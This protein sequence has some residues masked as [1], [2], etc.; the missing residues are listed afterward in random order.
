MLV[1]ARSSFKLFF[2]IENAALMILFCVLTQDI[3]VTPVLC[4]A[5][6]VWVCTSKKRRR[7]PAPL[8]WIRDRLG[9]TH[10][11]SHPG[12]PPRG[13]C[14]G[15]RLGKMNLG[16]VCFPK[17]LPADS[18]KYSSAHAES[19]LCHTGPLICHESLRLH[20]CVSAFVSQRRWTEN[21]GSTQAPMT[22]NRTSLWK[23]HRL[24]TQTRVRTSALLLS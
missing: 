24:G 19:R 11:S 21:V 17:T 22:T 9:A 5:G 23:E 7:A 18:E 15:S 8:L 4:Q 2:S 14:S 1:I 13:S 16:R 12:R 10:Q 3:L 6:Q 20:C